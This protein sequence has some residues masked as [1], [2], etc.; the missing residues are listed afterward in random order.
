MKVLLDTSVL[1]AAVVRN[2][3]H[4]ARAFAVLD[5][6]QGGKDDGFVCTH[7]LA[8]MYAVLT[9]LPPPSRHT[10]QEAMLSVQENVEKHFKIT[11]LDGAAYSAVIR[12]AALSGIRGCTIY[13]ALLLKCA[14][15]AGVA[16][17]FTFN[18]RHF[19][20]VAGSGPASWLSEP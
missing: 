5:R 6:V 16:R 9:S 7:S 15:N 2:H 18:L 19:Q 14:A 20:A 3:V 12:E 8:E 1:V 10:P 17:V 4:H 13:D 11:P